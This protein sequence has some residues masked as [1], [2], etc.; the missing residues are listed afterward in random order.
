MITDYREPDREL[1]K[2]VMQTVIDTLSSGVPT[3]LA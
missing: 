3:M 1:G 2:K